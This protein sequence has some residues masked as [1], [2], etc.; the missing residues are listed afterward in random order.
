MAKKK[1]VSYASVFSTGVEWLPPNP[2]LRWVEESP[3][4]G[5]IN[6]KLLPFVFSQ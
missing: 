4:L 1:L 6:N 3:T 5:P 2:E